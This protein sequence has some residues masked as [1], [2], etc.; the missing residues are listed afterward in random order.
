MDSVKSADQVA[1]DAQAKDADSKSPT[2]TPATVSGL[3]GAFAKKAAAKKMASG[4]DASNPR[5]TFMTSTTEVL[6]VVTEVAAAD[7]AV[8]AG[9]KENK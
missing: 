1:K 3:M 4:D 5:S 7:V 8:P 6:R 2:K 9:F